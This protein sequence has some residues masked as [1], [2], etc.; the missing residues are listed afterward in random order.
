MTTNEPELFD[1]AMDYQLC[2]VD[3]SPWDVVFK[4]YFTQAKNLSL[5]WGDDWN[6]APWEH[7]AEPPYDHISIEHDGEYRRYPVAIVDVF[8]EGPWTTTA[9]KYAPNSPYSVQ[10][11]NAGDAPWLLPDSW[12]RQKHP[13]P[14][15]AGT[16]LRDFIRIV[17]EHGGDVYLPPSLLGL[18]AA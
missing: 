1:D 11:I 13:P 3:E 15:M 6:D 4:V 12:N 9:Q 8:C 5:Q 7:N 16:S 18:V 2:F 14:I 10:D 17:T